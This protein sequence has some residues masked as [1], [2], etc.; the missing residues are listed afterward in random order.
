MASSSAN[1]ARGGT[2]SYPNCG[3]PTHVSNGVT[4][5][6]CGRTH[7]LAAARRGDI[8]TVEDPHGSCNVCR[9]IGC[10]EQRFYDASA[11]RNH[12]FCCRAHYLDAL[13]RGEWE[14]PRRG[15][16]DAG[17][18]ADAR[19]CSLPGC[20]T[21]VAR[22]P[23]GEDFDFCRREHAERANARG[24]GPVEEPHVERVLIGESGWKLKLLTRQHRDYDNIRSQFLN[25]W[26]K[27]GTSPRLERIFQVTV[28][29]H[30]YAQHLQYREHVAGKVGATDANVKR[31]FHG[32]S[33]TCKVGVNIGD[34]PCSA[35]GCSVCGILT[36]GFQTARAG[37]GAVGG[38]R[39][40][41]RY[42]KGIYSS[43]TSGKA[44]DYAEESGAAYVNK[45]YRTMF[46]VYVAA[47]KGYK[48]TSGDLQLDDDQEPPFDP[49]TGQQ[50]D[51]V[52]GEPSANG[53]LNYDELVVY[54][55][56]AIVP[57]FFIVY[58][59]L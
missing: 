52:I 7:A 49:K 43:A 44:N 30:I 55:S 12:D 13:A 38:Q 39:R 8:T 20:N 37:S 10:N 46:V 40:V 2:C 27:S 34:R 11:Q 35:P 5:D 6:Y 16:G 31:R 48:T 51:S 50:Y 14:A 28:A 25:K 18:D 42:G 29:D 21:P 23:G 58:S 47:G 26:G 41:L 53:D 33:S 4:H 3:R 56:S 57:A 59:L 1:H 36:H 45:M 19:R 9:L 54:N 24:L 22:G 32:T 15:R 17:A